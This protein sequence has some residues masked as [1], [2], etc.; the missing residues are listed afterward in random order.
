MKISGIYKIV[1]RATGR[2]YIGGSKDIDKRWYMHRDRLTRR[3]HH[4]YRLERD[5]HRY[6]KDG[7]EFSVVE[8]VPVEG[9]FE[10]EQRHLNI[11]AAN[12]K[13]YYNMNYSP[14]GGRPSD[15][16]IARISKKLKGRKLSAEHC[17]NISRGITGR[18]YSKETREKIGRFSSQRVHTAETKAKIGHSLMGGKRSE[19]TKRKMREACLLRREKTGSHRV[20][21]PRIRTFRSSDGKLFTGTRFDFTKRFSLTPSSVGDVIHG[22]RATVKGW[23]LVDG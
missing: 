3:E 11:C 8:E 17:Q 20:I 22:K 2:C 7:F 15:E 5:W 4:N 10:A 16:A 9:L 13:L 12:P 21:D 1:N 19:E 23:S 14:D 6:G 18:Y